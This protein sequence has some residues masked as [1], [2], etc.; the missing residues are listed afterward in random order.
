MNDSSVGPG[1]QTGRMPSLAWC[2]LAAAVLLSIGCGGDKRNTGDAAPPVE[3]SAARPRPEV[4][5]RHPV[6]RIDTNLGAITLR[7]DAVE[8]PGTVRNFLN[9]VADGFYANTLFHY[10]AADQMILGGGYT[11]AGGLKPAGTPIRNE[12]HNG[13]KNRRG[14]I[15]MARDASLGIDSA[16]C[17]FF[18][19]LADA[20]TLD[21]R[22]DS[23]GEYGYCVFGEVADGLD[24]AEQISRA[25][26]SDQGGDLVQMPDPPVVIRS[27]TRVK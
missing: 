26:T 2:A 21:Y 12:A 22:G 23:P 10:V 14:T 4:D 19:N 27:I 25:P 9:Y 20:P 1:A 13:L 3:F 15:A 24:V 11:A 7:L 8:A 18:I 5:A 17:Q 16:T 6:V